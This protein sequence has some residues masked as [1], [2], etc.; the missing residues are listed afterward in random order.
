MIEELLSS[1]HFYE[2]NTGLDDN[3][4]GSIIKSPLDLVLG[5][6]N[7]LEIKYPDYVT[8]T[9]NFY[10]FTGNLL[11][12]MSSQGLDLYEP[13]E[14][15]G[16]TAY[17][18]FPIYNR[19]WISTNYLTRRYRFVQQLL[20]GDMMDEMEM[21]GVDLI[22]FVRAKFDNS[23]AEDAESLIIAI[24]QYILPANEN[25]TF[26]DD[27]TSELT[28]ERLNY[29]RSAFLFSPQIDE[30]PLGTWTFRWNNPVENEVVRN[31]LRSL[32]N[33][34]LQSPEYQLM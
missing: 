33:A 25:L 34:M 16:Y 28:N 26:T 29:F 27:N 13:F 8:D 31:Q 22:D 32:F 11:R 18:Q 20:Q 15:V 1:Q 9:A 2:G 6:L 10:E 7:F 12:E 17:H 19:N 14:V 4:Y 24:S 30:N 21:E 5:T 3:N 23:I